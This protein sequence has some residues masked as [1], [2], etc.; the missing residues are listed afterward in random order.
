[1]ATVQIARIRCSQ[2]INGEPSDSISIIIAADSPATILFESSDIFTN[3]TSVIVGN[4][5]TSFQFNQQLRV[6]LIKISPTGNID[7]NPLDISASEQPFNGFKTIT[8][9]PQGPGLLGLYEIEYGVRSPHVSPV[10]TAPT[11][12]QLNRIGQAIIEALSETF[13]LLPIGDKG[14]ITVD[15]MQYNQNNFS[16]HFHVTI[17]YDQSGPGGFVG[18]IEGNQPLYKFTTFY[19]GDI[20]LTDP[21]GSIENTRYGW[22][23]PSFQGFGPIPSFGGG[24]VALNSTQLAA[25][26]GAIVLILA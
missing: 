15:Q 17:Q 12:N 5:P 10:H 18:Q 6:H 3:G 25:L 7:L 21:L 20:D 26:G 14:S 4:P 22:N 24:T 23:L 13:T 9:F 19:E 8:T 1:M 16:I 11:Q 2:T